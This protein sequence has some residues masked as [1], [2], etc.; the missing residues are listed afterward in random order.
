[1]KC[2]K[3]YNYFNNDFTNKKQEK[4]VQYLFC[5][6]IFLNVRIDWHLSII[7]VYEVI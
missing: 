2:K 7:M 1:M 4:H 5:N 6:K 3:I